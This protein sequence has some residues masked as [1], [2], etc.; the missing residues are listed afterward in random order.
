MG[1]DVLLDVL[2]SSSLD[3]ATA[4]YTS[5]EPVRAA[6]HLGGN[7]ARAEKKPDES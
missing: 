1:E 7:Q 5:G 4:G 3:R 6:F 2:G